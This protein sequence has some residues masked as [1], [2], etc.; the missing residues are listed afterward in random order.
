MERN[1]GSLAGGGN[2]QAHQRSTGA[3]NPIGRVLEKQ[4]G[5]VRAR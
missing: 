3:K 5:T 1:L 4:E 2:S